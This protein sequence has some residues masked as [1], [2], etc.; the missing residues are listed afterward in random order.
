MEWTLWWTADRVAHGLRGYLAAPIFAPRTDAFVLSEPQPLSGALFAPSFWATGSLELAYNLTLLALLVAGGL[1]ARRLLLRASLGELPAAFGGGLVVVL[2]FVHTELG[3]LPF[4]ALAGVVAT[5]D[6]WLRF[7]ARPTWRHAALLGVSVA[8]SYLLSCQLTLLFVV[9]LA[10]GGWP[11]FPPGAAVRPVLPRLAAAVALCVGLAAPLVVAQAKTT[12]ELDLSRSGETVRRLSAGVNEYVRAPWPST[13]G[14][15]VVPTHHKPR[16]AFFPGTV[17]VALALGGVVLCAR[18]RRFPALVRGACGVLAASVVVGTGPLADLG[19]VSLHRALAL[20]VPGFAQIRGL[21]HVAAFAQVSVALL[22]AHGLHAL[23][24]HAA[25]RER[26][27]RRW[28]IGAV[29]LG[30]A[31]TVELLPRGQR[32]FLPEPL[33]R[34]QGWTTFVRTHTP[35][36]ATLAFVPFPPGGTMKDHE[37]TARWMRL[38]AA[39]QRRMVNGYSSY[40]PAAHARLAREARSFPSPESLAALCRMGV[41][42]V[43]VDRSEGAESPSLPELPL[44][45]EDGGAGVTVHAL[46]CGQP[47]SARP[48]AQGDEAG[49]PARTLEVSVPSDAEPPPAERR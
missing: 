16:R 34:H 41:T 28:K 26:G 21:F 8:A 14:V 22:A 32:F 27:A 40:F 10:L 6:A 12:R 7:A 9:V 1:L 2:P 3:V 46:S 25:S 47:T 23:L 5:L 15:S 36:D 17:K 38:G 39:F 49:Q 48:G 13:F 31:A 43:V 18:R 45:H 20:V 19:P 42:H 44:L 33:E 11:A 24:A 30:L 35:D 29:A 4:I 37:P